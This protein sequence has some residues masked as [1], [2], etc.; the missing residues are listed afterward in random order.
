MSQRL[1]TRPK[2]I[3]G[4]LDSRSKSVQQICDMAR[5]P[6]GRPNGRPPGSYRHRTADHFLCRDMLRW[7]IAQYGDDLKFG[8][9]EVRAAGRRV[10]ARAQP[11]DYASLR[12]RA[13]RLAARFLREYLPP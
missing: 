13:R 9:A 2:E 7:L 6:T 11:G 1:A 10:A 12:S 8:D 3:R 4:L 5:R